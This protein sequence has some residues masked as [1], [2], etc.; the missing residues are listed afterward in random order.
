[1]S[2]VF[3]TKFTSSTRRTVAKDI[4]AMLV[5]VM[6]LLG[7]GSSA[8]A[9]PNQAPQRREICGMTDANGRF[10]LPTGGAWISFA[11]CGGPAQKRQLAPVGAKQ[12]R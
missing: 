4:S 1:M 5:A 9:Q 6:V 8:N 2:N 7:A 12:G 11:F 3:S 10:S